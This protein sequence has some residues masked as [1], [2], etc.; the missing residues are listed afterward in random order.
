MDRNN[1]VGALFD[2]SFEELVAIRFIK[3]LY[4]LVV[5]LIALGTAIFL[6]G[7]LGVMFGR[8]FLEG[9]GML[10][11][12]PLVALLYL[13][14]ARVWIEIIIVLFRIAE[15]T[16]ELVRIKR[17]VGASPVSGEAPPPVP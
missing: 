5:G 9:L 8:S 13:I 11:V 7:A 15:N 17:D 6:F 14:L 2:F 10:I 3:F 4:A 16:T 1:L 12:V